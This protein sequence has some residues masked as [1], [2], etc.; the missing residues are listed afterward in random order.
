MRLFLKDHL[1][2]VISGLAVLLAVNAKAQPNSQE[3]YLQCLTNFEAHAQTIFPRPL[4]F[5]RWR[6]TS[7]KS[8]KPSI[9]CYC[10]PS[11]DA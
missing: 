1:V 8:R 10:V 3:I 9:T 11:G 2:G 5:R 6:K 7:I 4:D